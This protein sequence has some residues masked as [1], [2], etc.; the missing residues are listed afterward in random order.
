M[1][2]QVNVDAD[3]SHRRQEVLDVDQE[4]N[5]DLVVVRHSG[6]PGF[7]SR[8]RGGTAADFLEPQKRLLHLLDGRQHVGNVHQILKIE[9]SNIN[10]KMIKYE[11]LGPRL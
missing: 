8:V 7:R 11:S 10:L 9:A 4:L 6:S 2:C 5:P 3:A 1:T